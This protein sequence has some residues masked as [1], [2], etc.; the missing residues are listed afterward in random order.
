MS[1]TQTKSLYARYLAERCGHSIIETEHGFATYE[2]L[3]GAVYIRDLYVTP[4]ARRQGHASQIADQ[5][6]DI[7]KA[8]GCTKLIGTIDPATHGAHESLLGLIAY[9]M[10]LSHLL[11]NL[12]VFTK[13]L[14]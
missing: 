11:G 12:I 9:G 10:R 4:E 13:E 7:A 3:D 6:C 5:V 14:S 1:S 2:W 8:R